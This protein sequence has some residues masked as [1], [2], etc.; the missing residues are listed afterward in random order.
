MVGLIFSG[1]GTVV[2]LGTAALVVRAT[3]RARPEPLL[4]M[5][6][7]D[8]AEEWLRQERGDPPLR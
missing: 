5:R 2:L 4:R 1:V 3:R 8:E 6:L 7:S